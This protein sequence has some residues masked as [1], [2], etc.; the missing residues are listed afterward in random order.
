VTLVVATTNPGK[1]REITDILA[2]VVGPSPRR[3]ELLTLH[4][5][6]TIVEPEETGATF[7]DNA[8]L[9]AVYYA[10]ATGLPCV[11]DDSGLEI[12]AL[13]NIPGVHS[14]RWEGTDY[15]VKFRRIYELLR[16]RGVTSSAARF[17]CYVAVADPLDRHEAG[18]L[19]RHEAGALETRSAGARITF[20]ADGIVNGEIAPAPRGTNGFGYDPIFYYPPFGCTLAELD[21]A[22]KATVSHRG[23]A[24]AKLR[25]HLQASL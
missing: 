20:E 25:A 5:F 6:P 18:T 15:A 8:R 23:Q 21:L 12:A 16:E 2:P 7:A 14:A 1:L 17:V 19:D 9:K 3:V 11:A 24:F 22:R 13:D 4:D 10:E